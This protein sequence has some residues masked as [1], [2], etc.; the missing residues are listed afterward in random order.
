M[1]QSLAKSLEIQYKK[2]HISVCFHPLLL[3][4]QRLGVDLLK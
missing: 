3:L 2:M 4:L 1:L